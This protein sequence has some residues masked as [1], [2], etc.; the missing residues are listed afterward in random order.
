MRSDEERL[1][2][3]PSGEW[4]G[5]TGDDE[6]G[7][8]G[9]H[10]RQLGPGIID[11]VAENQGPLGDFAE[12]LASILDGYVSK[13]EKHLRAIESSRAHFVSRITLS[14]FI[15][16]GISLGITAILVWYK[17]VSGEVFAAIVGFFVGSIV[18]F[19]GERIA[20]FL[21]EVGPEP[22]E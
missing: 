2:A 6:G 16:I 20:P 18:T 3:S 4:S 7:D 21:F 11:K 22:E 15:L 5:L 19:L 10:E 1:S 8:E 12:R 14:A 13:R 9:E 17:V